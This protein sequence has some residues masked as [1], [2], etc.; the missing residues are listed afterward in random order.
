[1]IGVQCQFLQVSLYHYDYAY[2]DDK[3]I[4]RIIQVAENLG[5]LNLNI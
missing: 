4:Q 1:M 5:N 3:V 2:N